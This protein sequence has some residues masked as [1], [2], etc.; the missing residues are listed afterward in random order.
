MKLYTEFYAIDIGTSSIKLVSLKESSA[1]VYELEAIKSVDLPLDI[2][3][4]DFT[5]PVIKGLPVFKSALQELIKL[6]NIA[7]KAAVIGLPDRW[8]KLYLSTIE[9]TENEMKNSEFLR[10]RIEKSLPIPEGLDVMVDYQVLDAKPSENG[11]TCE[12]IAAAVKKDIVEILSVMTTDLKIEVMA[13]DT[14][15]LG[16]FN[17]YEDR[18]PDKITEKAVVNLHIGNET[19]VF[20]AY[21]DGRL[22]YE[23]VIEVAGEEFSRVIAE[24][25][26]IDY[27]QAAK[28]KA[29]ETFFPTNREEMAASLEKRLRI[30]RIFGNWL[31]ELN[32]TYRFFQRR[33]GMGTVSEVFLTG[34][35][36][37]FVGLAGFLSDYLGTNCIVFNPLEGLGGEK[38]PEEAILKQGAVYAPCLGLLAK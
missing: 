30:E 12:V 36:A 17:L 3:G 28:I 15:S 10:W 8:V 5:A 32:V 9:I 4:G 1:N 33:F 38:K 26:A 20:K 14:S 11:Y 22:I 19:T 6:P 31:R 7:Q 18:Y 37:M 21:R 13:F 16:L 2:L 24:L 35:G 23:R 29:A 34:G 27:A 25:D